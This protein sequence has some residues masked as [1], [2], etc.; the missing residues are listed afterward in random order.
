MAR[1]VHSFPVTIPAGT[2]PT[3]P[4]V[5]A[6]LMP[7]R[8]VQEV[9]VL[10]PP[11][12]RGEVGFR[13]GS[14]G[15]QIL[16]QQLGQWIVTD[17]EVLH[18]PLEGLHDSGSWECVAYNTGLFQHTIT[19]RFLVNLPGGVGPVAGPGPIDSG[20]LAAAPSGNLGPPSVDLPPLPVIPDLGLPP[21]PTIPPLGLPPAPTL[22]GSAG[23]P[24]AA[25]TSST[26]S[27]PAYNWWYSDMGKLLSYPVQDGGGRFDEVFVLADGSVGVYGWRGGAGQ[28]ESWTLGPLN[29]GGTVVEVS[30]AWTL[31]QGKIRLNIVGTTAL[32]KRFI[33]VIDGETYT[34][35][36]EWTPAP[37]GQPLEK[38]LSARAAGA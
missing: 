3:A 11:G 18:W 8:E 5:Q 10:V 35:I 15:T 31:Y 4:L 19:V 37:D 28:W 32:G 14:S 38:T 16:P 21:A 12:P 9:E 1:E 23:V 27:Q 20:Q 25:G 33:K 22:P 17:N 13:V 2:V 6:M 24:G 7:A 29:V 34:T 36:L 26:S 30:A